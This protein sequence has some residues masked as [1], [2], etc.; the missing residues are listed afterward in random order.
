[1]REPKPE[2]YSMTWGLGSDLVS[3][4][5]CLGGALG[6]VVIKKIAHEACFAKRAKFLN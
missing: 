1:M 5:P 3:L 4:V 6:K 2:T